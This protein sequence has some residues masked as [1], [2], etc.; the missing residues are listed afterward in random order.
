MTFD[1]L[2]EKSECGELAVWHRPK[3]TS[4]AI[5]EVTLGKLGSQIDLGFA[6]NNFSEE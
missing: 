2:K 4:V 1:R 6:D 5:G 3:L